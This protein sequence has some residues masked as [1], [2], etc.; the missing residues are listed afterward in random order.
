MSGWWLTGSLGA[1]GPTGQRYRVDVGVVKHGA[2]LVGGAHRLAT[3]SGGERGSTRGRL[4]GSPRVLGSSSPSRPCMARG[5]M[6]VDDGVPGKGDVGR[7]IVAQWARPFIVVLPWASTGKAGEGEGEA[8]ERREEEG[9]MVSHPWWSSTEDTSMVLWDAVGVRASDTKFW[10]EAVLR[11]TADARAA[12][13]SSPTACRW[14]AVVRVQLGYVGVRVGGAGECDM[15]GF[16]KGGRGGWQ[17]MRVVRAPLG[18]RAGGAGQVDYAGLREMIGGTCWAE[19]GMTGG[20]TGHAC[21]S[22][23]AGARSSHR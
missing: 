13:T 21:Y 5:A 11:G 23:E 20:P 3:Q 19:G 15:R 12:T 22:Y 14:V 16:S 4:T 1:A 7:A 9:A 6:A 2:V 17:A 10:I 18:M 8:D